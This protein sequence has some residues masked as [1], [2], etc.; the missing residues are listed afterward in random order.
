MRALAMAMLGVYQR[1]VSPLLPPACRFHPTCSDYA[2]EAVR[3]YGVVRG[4]GLA[5]RRLARCHP[6]CAGG[7]DPVP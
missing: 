3:R 2:S 5:V 7:I 4:G 6:L 1:C